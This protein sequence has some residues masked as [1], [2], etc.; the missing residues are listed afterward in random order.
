MTKGEQWPIAAGWRLCL[1]TAAQLRL[2][3]KLERSM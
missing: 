3:T 1:C 2:P